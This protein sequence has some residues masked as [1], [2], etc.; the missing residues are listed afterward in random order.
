MNLPQ[1]CRFSTPA[2]INLFLRIQKKRADGFHDLLLDLLPVSLFDEIEL[3]PFDGNGLQL[4]G[5]LENL[6]PESNLVIKAVRLLEQE[7]K[8]L[9][10]LKIRLEK[11]IPT[12]AGLGG[13]SG[14]AAGMLVVLQRLLNLSI[15]EDRIQQ[16]ALQ[17]GADVPFFLKARPSL[18]RGIGEKLSQ[19]PDFSPLFL[20]LVYPGFSISTAEAYKICQISGQTAPLRRYTMDEL[21][22]LRPEMNDFWIPLTKR[23][24]ELEKCRTTLME[25]GAIAAGLSGSGSTI[26]SIFETR[27]QRDRV[28]VSLRNHSHWRIFPC[29]TLRQHKYPLQIQQSPFSQS[30]T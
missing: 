19:L 5:N 14:N 11:N 1:F 24:P 2:K 29:E 27:E 13:G 10:S 28:A 6:S 22:N 3:H 16:M 23:Y 9:F 21:T 4:E 20:L 25:R 30:A 7:V 12:G 17:L 26:F 15:P 8:Q 18:A